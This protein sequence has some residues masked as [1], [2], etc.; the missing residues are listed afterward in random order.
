M[1]RR[2]SEALD[3]HITGNYGEDQF[4]FEP[5]KDSAIIKVTEFDTVTL[6]HKH[7]RESVLR[8]HDVRKNRRVDIWWHNHYLDVWER[9]SIYT[10]VP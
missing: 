2:E 10:Y 4:G 1:D 9:R 7:I 8:N 3:R 6:P 5:D